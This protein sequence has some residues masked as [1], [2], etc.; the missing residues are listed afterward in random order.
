VKKALLALASVLV[1]L[2][3]CEAALRLAWHNPYR[4]EAA[5]QI[6]VLRVHHP[7]TDH[8]YDRSMIDREHP[9]VRFRTDDRSYVI[10][11]RRHETPDATVLFLG[12]STTECEIVREEARFPARVADLLGEQGYRVNSLNAARAGNTTQDSLSVLLSRAV[13]D[14]PDVAVMMHAV[15]DAGLLAASGGYEKRMARTMT[16]ADALRFAGQE[17]SSRS[18]LLGFFRRR[19]TAAPAERIREGRK[20]VDSQAAV[21]AS[22]EF[23]SRLRAFVGLCRAFGI[24]PVLMTQPLADFRTELTPS[25]VDLEVQPLFNEMIRQVGAETDVLVV[26]LVRFLEREVPDWN[27]PMKVFYD[28]MHVTDAGS[29]LYARAIAAR[30]AA[31]VLPR[32]RGA[33]PR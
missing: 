24:E 3:L 23:V 29:E 2:A 5:D 17:G 31:E 10:P 32:L 18:S 21:A 26:D 14:R 9:E 13:A 12:G 15:N 30:L 22:G 20:P 11:S 4:N 16:L 33:A 27:E 28:G 1:T 8:V 7:R 25:W 19:S 6:L